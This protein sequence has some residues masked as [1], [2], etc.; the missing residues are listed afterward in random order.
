[1]FHFGSE[2][3]F[4]RNVAAAAAAAAAAAIVFF[5]GEFF[6]KIIF[7]SWPGQRH[8]LFQFFI[9]DIF[10][11]FETEI[12]SPQMWTSLRDRAIGSFGQS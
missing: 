7:F 11:A 2:F 8:R 5:K 1:M 3:P 10:F 6:I 9:S 4:F 12:E